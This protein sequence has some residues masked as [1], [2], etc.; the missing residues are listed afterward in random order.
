MLAATAHRVDIIDA[1]GLGFNE[2][3]ARFRFGKGDV[4]VLHHFGSAMAAANDRVHL[5]LLGCD[6]AS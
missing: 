6:L 4:L 3:L 1:D 2:H 5:I